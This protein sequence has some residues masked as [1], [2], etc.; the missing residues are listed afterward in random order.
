M[1]RPPDGIYTEEVKRSE[2]S[3]TAPQQLKKGLLLIPKNE[4]KRVF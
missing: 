1:Q 3:A 4:F 2:E